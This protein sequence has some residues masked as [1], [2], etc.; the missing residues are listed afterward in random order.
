[1]DPSWTVVPPLDG[2][3]APEL[4]STILAVDAELRVVGLGGPLLVES[5]ANVLAVNLIRHTAGLGGRRTSAPPR[6]F[7]ISARIA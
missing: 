5:L 7:R 2:M 1:M 4:R 6:R 3:N